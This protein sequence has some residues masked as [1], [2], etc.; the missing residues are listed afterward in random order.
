MTMTAKKK[1]MGNVIRKPLNENDLNFR[2]RILV[3]MDL[4]E[5]IGAERKEICGNAL[6]S[7]SHEPAS[8]PSF[9]FAPKTTRQR[10]VFQHVDAA[11]SEFVF[12]RWSMAA[13]VSV[14]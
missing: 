13:Q 6:K 8:L 3:S 9:S 12:P 14:Y 7:S 5:C 2:E 11:V 4:T 1:L 10:L